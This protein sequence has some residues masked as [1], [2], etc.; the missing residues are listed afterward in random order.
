M[1]IIPIILTQ[2]APEYTIEVEKDLNMQNPREFV[3][4]GNSVFDGATL[5]MQKLLSDHTGW[6]DYVNPATGDI[7]EFTIGAGY[8]I[9]FYDKVGSIKFVA[10][11]S[12]IN[13]DIRIDLIK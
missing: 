9:T 3:I 2:T 6:T 8:A 7:V 4:G 13:T 5:K 11:G 12:G 10:T 1:S